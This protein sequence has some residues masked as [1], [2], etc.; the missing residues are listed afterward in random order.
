MYIYKLRQH[1]SGGATLATVIERIDRLEMLAASKGDLET[2]RLL[3]E[4]Q[5]EKLRRSIVVSVHAL[6]V[7]Q[8]AAQQAAQQ[9]FQRRNTMVWEVPIRE[10]FAKGCAQGSRYS[11]SEATLPDGT[12]VQFTFCPRGSGPTA[13]D[14][15]GKKCASLYAHCGRLCGDAEV[16][17]LTGDGRQIVKRTT[18]NDDF[19]DGAGWLTMCRVKDIRREERL[20]IRATFKKVRAH[21]VVTSVGP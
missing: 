2:L 14:A 15:D 3:Q 13:V 17:I 8:E 12:T 20:V 19:T 9:D 21:V 7:S 16:E 11:S 18:V 10:W 4:R 1:E 5:Q 6:R